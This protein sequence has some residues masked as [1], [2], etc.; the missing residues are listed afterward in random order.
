VL[1]DT[2]DE[3]TKS[4]LRREPAPK[5]AAGMARS[6]LEQM[7]VRGALFCAV[8]AVLHIL[9]RG[10][11][12]SEVVDAAQI[13]TGAVR[14]PEGHPHQ[15]FY[16][17]APALPNFIASGIWL[18][19]PSPAVVSAVFNWLFLFLSLFLPFAIVVTLTGRM[20]WG[21]LAVALTLV[22]GSLLLQGVYPMWV[23][24]NFYV[25][26]H[27]GIHLA[28]L[29]VLFS[30]IG[31]WRSAG[32]ILGI[33][34]AFHAPMA[35]LAWPWLAGYGLLSG[36]IGDR[37]AIRRFVPTF[38]AGVSVFAVLILYRMVAGDTNPVAPYL[39]GT[40]DGQ[41]VYQSFAALTDVHARP[42]RL[43]SIAYGVGS[44]IALLLGGAVA[45]VR[46]RRRDEVA[47][48][49][50]TRVPWLL[51]F[52]A[53]VW[54]YVFGAWVYQTYIGPLPS[55]IALTRPYR[56]SNIS[57][58]FVIPFGV[59][60]LA[61]LRDRLD[62]TLQRR[63]YLV[64]A[65]GL[66]ALVAAKALNPTAGARLAIPGMM[67]VL[68]IVAVIPLVSR[69]PI[70]RWGL[71]VAAVIGV[72]AILV[73]NPSKALQQLAFF[74]A[75]VAIL[76]LIPELPLLAHSSSSVTKRWD[77]AALFA[78]AL[79]AAIVLVGLPGYW[80]R[81]APLGP[82]GTPNRWDR[83]WSYDREMNQWLAANTEPDEMILP[84]MSPRSEIP[85]KTGHP[86]LIEP[87]TLYL[88]S[89]MPDR[90][91]V[92]GRMV[93]DLYGVR[94]GDSAWVARTAPSGRLSTSDD[95][96]ME[97]WR[98]RT[99]AEWQEVGTRYDFRLVLAPTGTPLDL[100]LGFV[101]SMWSIY[102]IPRGG[103]TGANGPTDAS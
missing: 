92:V 47:Q 22:E 38:V 36:A 8:L 27:I 46:R 81:V 24:P 59:A 31:Y 78:P 69:R 7:L 80:D 71:I 93:D 82:D 18:V 30:V 14:Y 63:T 83:V 5:V 20:A 44:V 4:S 53:L 40:E 76:M 96:W 17:T 49:G 84:V 55:M 90:A 60:L 56:F 1:R 77:F 50:T 37:T 35:L 79:V 67:L 26:G 61:H 54:A 101:G 85:A 75:A 91:G 98:E 51:G 68:F 65:A 32:L 66:I 11:I 62:A 100:P 9:L 21:V 13:I 95:V 94:Y 23:L 39:P 97:A 19:T 29:G 103:S 86:V 2:T 73:I 10:V 6:S 88:M 12:L 89:Y 33:L 87:P 28:S 34:P 3:V 48:Q 57:A 15:V 42:F 99:R 72:A 64:V 25:H 70:V 58:L 102:V 41:A 74:A 16:S 52:I 45:L 43:T